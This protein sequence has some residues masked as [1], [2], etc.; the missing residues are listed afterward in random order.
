[1]HKDSCDIL[2]IEESTKL[3]IVEK[4]SK[5]EKIVFKRSNSID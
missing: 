4:L 1:V 5:A 2:I 3:I